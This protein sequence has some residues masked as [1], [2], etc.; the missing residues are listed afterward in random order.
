MSASVFRV[1]GY[2]AVGLM[3]PKDRANV[4]AVLRAAGC[5]G[6]TLVVTQ[7][8]RYAQHGTDTSK[9]HKHLPLLQVADLHE[10][11]PFDCV[12]V[13]V[14]M[15]PAARSLFDYSHPERAF[16]VFGPEDGTLG[17]DTLAWCRDV[18]YIP[19]N[20]CLNL[21]ASVNVVLYDRLRKAQP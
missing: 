7:G 2:A 1:R 8:S 10:A 18:I 15:V 11:I 4:G 16:Y 13:A 21:A 19:T 14:E 12:P 9:A 20:G 5:F 6:V 17:K 3:Q